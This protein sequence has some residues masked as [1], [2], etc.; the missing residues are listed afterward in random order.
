MCRE[1]TFY[2]YCGHVYR[3]TTI[4]C[5][6]WTSATHSPEP[7]HDVPRKDHFNPLDWPGRS[8]RAP[9]NYS[10]SSSS[11]SS[12]SLSLVSFGTVSYTTPSSRSISPAI[13][14]MTVPARTPKKTTDANS[15]NR[16]NKLC[17]WHI[18]IPR[19]FPK[20]CSECESIA[21]ISEYLAQSPT[22]RL[23]IIRDWRTANESSKLGEWPVETDARLPGRR[24]SYG[25]S[26]LYFWSGKKARAQAF[27]RAR[28]VAARALS[29]RVGVEVDG[30]YSDALTKEKEELL[31]VVKEENEMQRDQLG[32]PPRD[33]HLTAEDLEVARR[34]PGWDEVW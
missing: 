28:Q 10:S 9:S 4:P 13:S 17:S 16:T 3:K 12:S 32:A 15:S 20:L 30:T 8:C 29:A 21:H 6:H 23:E 27:A 24:D 34:V 25:D 14:P 5:K 1:Y 2:C 18:P 26:L 19:L 33:P 31:R 7:R 22:T 11:S